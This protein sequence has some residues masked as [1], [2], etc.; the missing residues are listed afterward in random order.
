MAPKLDYR[1]N[2]R[3]VTAERGMFQ[4]TDLIDPERGATSNCRRA[5]ST[6]WWSN[7]RSD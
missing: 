2:L 5:R 4:T 6:G 3:S 7:D 1:W